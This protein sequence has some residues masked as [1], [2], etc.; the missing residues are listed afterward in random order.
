MKP[1]PR[2]G[3]RRDNTPGRGLSSI[4]PPAHDPALTAEVLARID[5]AAALLS[6]ALVDP[7]S[8]IGL[9]LAAETAIRLLERARLYLSAAA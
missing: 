9:V 2:Q 5:A 8:E 7:D 3:R 1:P 4:V 6:Y